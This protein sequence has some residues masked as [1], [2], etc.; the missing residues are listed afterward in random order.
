[1]SVAALAAPTGPL[2]LPRPHRRID[3]LVL[4]ARRE[5]AEGGMTA[6]M[7]AVTA[8]LRVRRRHDH[9]STKESDAAQSENHCH[10]GYPCSAARPERPR[11]C[12]CLRKRKAGPNC[13]FL[14]L[15]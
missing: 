13:S 8:R 10:V 15:A 6:V 5:E 3:G 4:G 2:R 9:C 14:M 7:M 1:P 11:R 12:S